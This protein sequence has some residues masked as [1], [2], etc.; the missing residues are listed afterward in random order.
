M[1]FD[2]NCKAISIEEKPQHPK[3]NYCISGLFFYNNR[4]VEYAKNLKTFARG[5][6]EIVEL[7][8]IYLEDGTLNCWDRASL[9]WILVHMRIWWTQLTS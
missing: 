6:L 1:E 9:G 4:V 8:R 7:N 3:S 5:E 2:K